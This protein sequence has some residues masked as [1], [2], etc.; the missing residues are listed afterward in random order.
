MMGCLSSK[1]LIL[2]SNWLICLGLV[3]GPKSLHLVI[4][5]NPLKFEPYYFI[6]NCKHCSSTN[7]ILTYPLVP[8]SLP[9]STPNTIHHSRLTVCLLDSLNLDPMPKDFVLDKQL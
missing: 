7:P 6:P 8:I 9:V 1:F 2:T 3:P 5:F 4:N